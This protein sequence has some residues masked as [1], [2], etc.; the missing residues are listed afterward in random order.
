MHNIHYVYVCTCAGLHD[1]ICNI[2]AMCTEKGG[3]NLSAFAWRD[4]Y[5]N[6]PGAFA[7]WSLGHFTWGAGVPIVEHFEVV[8]SEAS[9][10]PNE[11]TTEACWYDDTI[12]CPPNA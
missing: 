3:W 7:I 5:D 9:Y 6:I 2:K 11:P 4:E 10:Y 8:C 1:F 12:F